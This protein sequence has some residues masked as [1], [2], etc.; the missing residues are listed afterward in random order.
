MTLPCRVTRSLA[1]YLTILSLNGAKHEV[2]RVLV[3][4]RGRLKPDSARTAIAADNLDI[5]FLADGPGSAQITQLIG[6]SAARPCQRACLEARQSQGIDGLMG[7]QTLCQS[8]RR[9]GKKP[10][11]NPK[12]EPFHASPPFRLS[13]SGRLPRAERLPWAWA[14]EWPA[15]VPSD[16]QARPGPGLPSSDLRRSG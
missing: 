9:Q 8:K 7:L 1:R 10:G 6:S 11:R 5:E 2:M 4:Q 16:G 13:P 12:Q 3:L 14:A 15:R